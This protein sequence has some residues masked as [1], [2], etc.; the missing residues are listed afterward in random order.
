MAGQT[1]SETPTNGRSGDAEISDATRE[2]N[3]A[4]ILIASVI[5]EGADVVFGYPGGASLEIHQAITR[6]DL[7]NIL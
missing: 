2:L 5:R 7:R 4:D 3:G 1:D 6:S